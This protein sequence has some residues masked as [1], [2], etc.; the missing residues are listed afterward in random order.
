MR[1]E[2]RAETDRKPEESRGC[3][4]IEDPTAHCEDFVCIEN[5][6]HGTRTRAGRP[7]RWLLRESQPQPMATGTLWREEM[8]RSWMYLKVEPVGFPYRLEVGC[9][10]EESRMTLRIW[11][12]A[13]GRGTSH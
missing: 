1:S 13:P 2:G 9:E 10:K 3:W 6:L 12:G 11:P 5:R 4:M 7:D 8:I